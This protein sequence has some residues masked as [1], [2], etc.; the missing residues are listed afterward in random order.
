MTIAALIAS[1]VLV[2][3][4]SPV[5]TGLNCQDFLVVTRS[6]Y[7]PNV[8]ETS[9]ELELADYIKSWAE[10]VSLT[11]LFPLGIK[12]FFIGE[13][14]SHVP[15]KRWLTLNMAGLKSLGVTHLGMEAFNSSQQTILDDFEKRKNSRAEVVA[16]LDQWGWKKSEYMAVV[17]AARTN[18]IRVVA[19]DARDL[20]KK[21]DDLTEDEQFQ[22]R[23][24]HMA[25]RIADAI[26]SDRQ[27]RMVVLTGSYHAH[28]GRATGTML[29]QP[30]ILK[31]RFGIAS[32]SYRVDSAVRQD[33]LRRCAVRS[34]RNLNKLFVPLRRESSNFDGY[35]F[36]DDPLYAR[37]SRVVEAP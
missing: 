30:W 32:V 22:F 36:L 17:K 9:D 24:S 6:T 16:A 31:Q 34:G 2:G 19:L 3:H 27:A 20:V 10:P 14:H 35:L 21:R 13:T 15:P 25:D 5:N 1:F 12:V 23:D 37:G 11:R 26:N 8:G 18:G 29:C 4:A 33:A 28:C 7:L